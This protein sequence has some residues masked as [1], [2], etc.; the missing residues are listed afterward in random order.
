MYF[1]KVQRVIFVHVEMAN[2]P[3]GVCSF[4]VIATYKIHRT[5]I[6]A[7]LSIPEVWM[8]FLKVELFLVVFILIWDHKNFINNNYTIFKITFFKLNVMSHCMAILEMAIL[9]DW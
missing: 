7:Y 4:I 2:S 8:A 1:L 6:T 5:S 9:D 3:T